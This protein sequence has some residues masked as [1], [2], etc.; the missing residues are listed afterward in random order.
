MSPCFVIYNSGDM[1]NKR[2]VNC[3]C[4]QTARPQTH[5]RAFNIYWPHLRIAGAFHSIDRDGKKHFE[6][7]DNLREF[8]AE[9]EQAIEDKFRVA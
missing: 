6:G 4:L 1:I 3:G 8:M 9:E 2:I 5:S 7:A